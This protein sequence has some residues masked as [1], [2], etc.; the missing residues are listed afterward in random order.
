MYA[1]D[2][3]V[4][5]SLDENNKIVD[6]TIS[7]RDCLNLIVDKALDFVRTPNYE[8]ALRICKKALTL[9][10]F[11]NITKSFTSGSLVKKPN[12]SVKEILDD[13]M[14]DVVN[15]DKS[16]NASDLNSSSSAVRDLTIGLYEYIV[17]TPIKSDFEDFKEVLAE[18]HL[19]INS[20]LRKYIKEMYIYAPSLADDSKMIELSVVPSE[21]VSV[22]MYLDLA[23]KIESQLNFPCIV[24]VSYNPSPA[25][26]GGIKIC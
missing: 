21:E 1:N 19:L 17:G 8:V 7:I 15:L 13:L 24:D 16:N 12:Q 11:L 3:I 22:I 26:I 23:G 4:Y 6:K 20:D 14:E 5:K 2:L 10:D 25:V 9:N 18:L